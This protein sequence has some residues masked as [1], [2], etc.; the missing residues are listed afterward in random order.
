M[1]L[2]IWF[3]AIVTRLIIVLFA[4][5]LWH[6]LSGATERTLKKMVY[7]SLSLSAVSKYWYIFEL[8]KTSNVFMMG[9]RQ[10][11]SR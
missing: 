1:Q 5:R 11:S 2:R 3:E 6:V 4:S 9:W 8:V 7:W 10:D